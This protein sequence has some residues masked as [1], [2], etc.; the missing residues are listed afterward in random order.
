MLDR[1]ETPAQSK[2]HPVETLPP[3]RPRGIAEVQPSY[4]PSES[5]RDALKEK[6]ALP[7]LTAERI[8]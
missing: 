7:E 4:I 5:F 3:N 2:P 8:K 1:N 6:C